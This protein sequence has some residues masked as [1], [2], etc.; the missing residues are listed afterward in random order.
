MDDAIEL[1][2]LAGAAYCGHFP[3]DSERVYRNL[4]RIERRYRAQPKDD[5]G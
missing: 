5:A 1:F 4:E 2:K 3:D